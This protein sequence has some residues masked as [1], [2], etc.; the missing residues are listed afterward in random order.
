MLHRRALAAAAALAVL[1]GSVPALAETGTR[2]DGG[3]MGLGTVVPFAGLLLSIAVL[4]LVTPR[5]WH[6]HYGKVTA[7]WALLGILPIANG[8][9]WQPALSEVLHV[10]LLDYIPFVILL[11]TLYVVTGGIRITGRLL[12]TPEANTATLGIGTILAGFM[13]T[14]GA[15]MLLIRPILTANENRRYKVHIFVFLIFLVSNVGGALSPL[16]DPP[17]FLGFLR[18]IEF[19]WPTIHLL[20]PTAVVAVILLSMFYGIDMG[21]YRRECASG[22]HEAAPC[23]GQEGNI[24]IEG[25]FNAMILF[26]VLLAVL[27]SGKF[28]LLGGIDVAGFHLD[29]DGT[30]RD[31]ILLCLTGLSLR[32]TAPGVRSSNSFSWGPIV[33]VAL[34]F[35]GIFITIIA[36]LAI[37]RAGQAGALGG[38]MAHLMDEGRPVDAMFFWV[39]GALSSFL[40]NAP[41]YLVF[42]NVAGGDPQELMGP[43][44]TTLAAISAG[45][46]YMGAMTYIGNAPNLMVKSIVESQ[47]VAMP[48]FFGYMAWSIGILIPVFALVTLLFF[49]S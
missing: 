10:A 43:L 15:S 47:G 2:I 4:P 29:L 18:G 3:A 38:F 8:F 34:L 14:T 28:D 36:P 31:V 27:M 35:A 13:G 33:E 32:L 25:G 42:F 11:A 7:G 6:R 19:F 46:V 1:C 17:L 41:T 9:G 12:G 24:R 20:L 49:R 48:S 30:L 21:L 23:N 40:D 37:L 16:G 22:L 45:A 26:A 44:A 5:F 39:T